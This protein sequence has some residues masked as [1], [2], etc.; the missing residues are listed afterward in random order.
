MR[1]IGN[2]R[3]KQLCRS[4]DRY[5]VNV[6]SAPLTPVERVENLGASDVF[7]ICKFPFGCPTVHVRVGKKKLG[8]YGKRWVSKNVFGYAVGP[9]IDTPGR[10][11]CNSDYH[12][13]N[14]SCSQS[15]RCAALSCA[16]SAAFDDSK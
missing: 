11:W 2:M 4:A 14:A 8:P 16:A 6:H 7:K 15:E 13:R 12:T 9:D 10:Q 1:S 3:G 5:N